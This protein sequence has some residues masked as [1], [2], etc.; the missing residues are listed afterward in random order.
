MWAIHPV[1]CTNVTVRAVEIASHGP[2]ND[3]CDP[4]ACR[5][6]LIEDCVFDAGDDCISIKSGQK[7]DGRRIGAPSENIIIRRCQMK[8]GRG[9]V[10]IG[11]EIS[12]G[13]RNLF[14][15]NCKMDSPHLDRAIG[16]KSSST[17]GGVIEN[18]FVR[19]I[20]VGTVAGAALQID[21]VHEEGP[22]GAHKPVLRNLVIENLRVQSAKRVLDVQGFQGSEI[23][24]VRIHN[25]MFKG[26]TNEDVVKEADVKII[27]CEI[28]RK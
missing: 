9:G 13:A 14:V 26:I 23:S 8:G 20:E 3:G 6:V 11:S 24:G 27:E 16:F 4:E 22:N 1:L 7:E 18:I 12:G 25:S 15:E 19:D 2:N 21:F 10:T 5:D 17:C 28:E